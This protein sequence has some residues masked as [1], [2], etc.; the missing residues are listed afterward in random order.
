MANGGMVIEMR[1]KIIDTNFM[2]ST[3]WLFKAET[4]D[5]VYYILTDEEYKKLKLKSPVKRWHLDSLMVGDSINMEFKEINGEN[6]IV[7]FNKV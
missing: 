7:E 6:V 5:G 1:A 2:K 4:N 3:K